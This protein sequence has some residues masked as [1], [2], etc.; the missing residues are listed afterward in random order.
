MYHLDPRRNLWTCRAR[1][2]GR[3]GLEREEHHVVR[4]GRAGA[5]R[6]PR[7]LRVL[8]EVALDLLRI[9]Q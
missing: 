6:E 5:V 2:I 4:C 8:L 7:R 1:P 9:R 3:E